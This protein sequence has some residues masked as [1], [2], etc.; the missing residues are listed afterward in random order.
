MAQ[1][2][3]IERK[4][5]ALAVVGGAAFWIT[6]FLIS[7]TPIA[8]E[9]RVG[10]SISYIPMLLEAAVGGLL[11]GF[12][13]SYFLLRSYDKIPTKNPIQKA[14]ILSLIALVVLTIILEVP[15]KFLTN[16]YD[17]LHFF[18]IGLLF[19]MLRIP[20]LGLAVGYQYRRRHANS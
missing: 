19:N 10:L 11:I 9:Y 7:L 12:G 3:E 5:L 6:N 14:V 13:V 8:A 2:R 18:L 15:S 20:A 4:A 16:T 17:A 1:I